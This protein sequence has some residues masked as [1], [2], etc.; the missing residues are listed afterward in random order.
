MVGSCRAQKKGKKRK[1]QNRKQ[2]G[3]VTTWQKAAKGT[4]QA[5]EEMK[6]KKT[7]M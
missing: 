2:N 3:K 7:L 6:E 5:P 4:T 1:L